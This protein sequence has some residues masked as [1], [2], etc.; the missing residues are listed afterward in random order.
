MIYPDNFEQKTGFDR[1]RAMIHSRMLCGLGVEQANRF[2]FSVDYNEISRRLG[3][4]G[5]FMQ[6]MSMDENIPLDNF[7]DVTDELSSIRIEGTYIDLHRLYDFY[8]SLT[9]VKSLLNFIKKLNPSGYP[10]LRNSAAGVNYFPVLLDCVGDILTAKGEIRD[11][12]SPELKRIRSAIRQAE[13]DRASRLKNVLLSARRDGLIAP[14]VD[15]TMR[16]GRLVIP[17]ERSAKHKIDGY[18][19]DESLSGKTV[20][21]EPSVVVEANNR[22]R[23]LEFS[24]SR[25]IVR[26]LLTVTDEI[27]PYIDDL[28]VTF[29]FL[30]L[31]DYLHGLSSFSKEINAVCPVLKNEPCGDW[32]NAVHPLLFLLHRNENKKVIPHSFQF[33]DDCRILLISGPNAGGKSVLLQLVALLQY[34]VQCGMPVPVSEGSVMGV[35]NSIFLAMGDEQSIDNDLSTYSSHLNHLSYFLKYS[36]K[37]TMILI[38]EFGAGTEPV[39]G[40]ALAEA[41]LE[42]LN[43]SGCYGVITT[44]YSNLKQY[45]ASVRGIMNAA[46]LFDTANLKPL[47]QLRIGEPGSSFAFEIAGQAGIPRNVLQRATEKVGKTNLEF[48]R[49]I[50]DI[51][52]EKVQ[53]EDLRQQAERE[54]EQAAQIRQRLAAELAHLKYQRKDIILKARNEA[55]E[56]L[57]QANR[58]IENTIRVIKESQAGKEKTKVARKQLSDQATQIRS[59]PHTDEQLEKRIK[60]VTEQNQQETATETF[61]AGDLVKISGQSVPGIIQSIRHGIAAI[62]MG[63][64]ILH[65]EL[66]R[67]THASPDDGPVVH[68]RKSSIDLLSVKMNFKPEIDLR[69]KR[70]NEAIELVQRLIDDAVMTGQ[71]SLRIL[72]GKGDGILRH[73]IREYLKT[74]KVI[75]KYYDESEQFGGAGITII[76][77]DI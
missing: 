63:H 59:H 1:I 20:F 22:L 19:H 49:N 50:Q 73:M 75:K 13:N 36:D 38:D 64:S 71:P 60:A 28:F 58:T 76:E 12:A 55:D 44:H 67:L 62:E 53:W 17:V 24:E 2:S 40:G 21:I 9:A 26:I 25:E 52:R 39:L 56:L 10:H 30:G 41:I 4:A 72:H 37:H 29:G 11:D 47:Y 57:T 15:L 46:M 43:H 77:L 14:D 45:A 23:E 35:F 31:I 16:N 3:L 42:E 70:T 33:N 8:R 74:E 68:S 7:F 48:E 54:K 27:R 69:G 5:E 51:I 34:M 66:S 61:V 65:V 6:L 18:V 32:L